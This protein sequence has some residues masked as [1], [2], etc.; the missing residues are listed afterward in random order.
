MTTDISQRIKEELLRDLD[1]QVEYEIDNLSNKDFKGP[2][3]NLAKDKQTLYVNRAIKN[4]DF[5]K[6]IE[7][8]AGHQTHLVLSASPL[9][10]SS[11][12]LQSLEAGFLN[13]DL[14]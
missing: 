12:N 11:L 1:H 13:E 14:P 2:N 10:N 4:T 6:A 8:I 3:F 5:I 9:A 7:D